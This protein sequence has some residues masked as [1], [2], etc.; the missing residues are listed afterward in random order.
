MY[1][2]D[3]V[4]NENKK[5]LSKLPI[6]LLCVRGEQDENYLKSPDICYEQLDYDPLSGGVYWEKEYPNILYVANGTHLTLKGFDCLFLEGAHDPEQKYYPLGM[7]HAFEDD[8]PSA[9]ERLEVLDKVYRKHYDYVFSHTC[10]AE[11][12]KDEKRIG[13]MEAYLSDVYHYIS[14]TYWFYGH[15][16]ENKIEKLD[17]NQ[18]QQVCFP[19]V[20]EIML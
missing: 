20:E 9:G 3:S 8:M 1:W 16:C 13:P 5:F 14:F 10:P 12:V 6:A 2:S 19:Y 15:F 4:E 11:W 17:G 7:R 18:T